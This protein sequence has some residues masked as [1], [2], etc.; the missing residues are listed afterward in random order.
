VPPAQQPVG[1]VVLLHT[2]APPEQTLPAPQAAP[3]PQVHEPVIGSQPSATLVL[4][5]AQALPPTPQVATV[6]ALQV[7]FTQQPFGQDWALQTHELPTHS[8]PPPQAGLVPQ[9]HSPEAEQRLARLTSHETQAAPLTPQVAGAAPVQ[10]EPEQHPLGQ[11]AG[12]QPLQAPPKQ[13]CAPQLWQ[14]AP[15]LP[16]A[17]L[18]VPATQ[19]VPEQQPFGHDVPSH[20]QLPAR[21]RCPEAHSEPAPQAHAPLARHWL[22]VI[23]HA[24]QAPPPVPQAVSVG[25][26]QAPAA[27]QPF[28][29]ETPSQTQRPALQC[30]PTAH[31]PPL[32]HAHT[33]E[34]EQ[35]SARTESQPTHAAP[36]DPQVV[37]DGE[38]HAVPAQQPFGQ[39][40]ASQAQDPPEQ[41]W[42]AAQAGRAPQAHVP[43]AEQ[44]SA[45]RAS[46]PTQIAPPAPQV[47]KDGGLQVAPEQQPFAQLVALQPLQAPPTQV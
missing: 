1:Q 28:G 31:I 11:L 13:V 26:R 15:P 38:L 6:G 37:S 33:P 10:V 19:V 4:H 46:Q 40:L 23:P 7:P 30:W 43:V 24:V 41:R 27:Q 12:L 8:V 39:L 44:L 34:G 2:Q 47:V 42:P 3:L 29:Q 45:R 18:D 36:P 17:E 32:P 22:A 21:Q 5:V 25:V 9:R 16:Q 35:P 14:A 20:T